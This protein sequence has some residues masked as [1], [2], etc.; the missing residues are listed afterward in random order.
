VAKSDAFDVKDGAFKGRWKDRAEFVLW[1]ANE[2]DLAISARS[3]VASEIRHNWDYYEQNRMRANNAPWPDA[4]DLPSP[5]A[6]EY[7]DAVHARLM[8]TIFV[9]NVWSV[10]GFG[11]SA[12]RAPFVEEFHQKAQ[13]DERLQ[14]YADEWVLRGLIEGVGTLE[15]TEA[16]ETRREIQRKRVALQLDPLTQAPILGE[17][18]PEL[19]TDPESGDY[20]ATDDPAVPSAEVDIDVEE[21]VRLGPEY[22]VIPYTDFGVLPAHARNRKQVWG[23]WKRFHRRVPE[24]QHCVKKGIYD[25]DGVEKAG[26][27]NDF[28]NQSD[29]APR[30]DAAPVSQ[31][32]PT[33]QKELFE[34][35]VLADIDG[36]GERWWRVTLQKDRR[37][38]LRLKYDDR[39]TRYIRWMP[40]PKPGTM[41]RG[42]SLIGNK[43]ITVLEEDT[44]RRNMTADRMAMVAGQPIKKLQGSLWDEFEQPFGPRAVITVRDMKE[45]EPMAGIQDVP[46]SV[47]NWRSQIRDDA[48]RLIGQN[49]VAQGQV[50]EEKRTLGEVQLV[51]GYAEVR[52][53]LLIKRLQEPMEELGLARHNIWKRTLASNPNLPPQRALVIGREAQGIDQPYVGDD[54]TVTA[55]MLEGVFWFK[56]RGSVETA[57]LNRQRQDFVGL[58]QVLPGIVQMSPTI[59]AIFQTVP[60]AKALV[61]NLLRV[62]RWP[63]R[64]SFIGSEANSVFDLMQQQQEMAR[65]PQMQILMAMAGGGGMGG[66]MPQG[67]LPPGQAQGDPMAGGP[68]Q[69]LM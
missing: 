3:G 11:P 22:D 33:A 16:V 56:P 64:Q 50:S 59:G 46:A 51:A 47:M 25:K 68:P 67:Q 27:D 55:E 45:V 57:D 37:A 38:L 2:L 12:S 10:E 14:Q 54:G 13:E 17:D 4:A 29:T 32:G 1:L 20:V 40:F 31:D 28:V 6:P 5:Y 48:D 62:F 8:Q 60:A 30:L 43:L 9:E 65:D 15:I 7:T 44:A 21:P 19:A 63:D 61:E 69:G 58:L 18:G 35:Q 36:K 34:C 52:V 66:G 24:L 49:D 23:Y 39:T 41:D 26:T 53:N 42:Y